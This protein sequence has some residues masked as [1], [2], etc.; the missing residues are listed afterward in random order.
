MTGEKTKLPRCCVTASMLR[1]G[2]V[3][4]TLFL[5]RPGG[6]EGGLANGGGGG[7]GAIRASRPF[8]EMRVAMPTGLEEGGEVLRRGTSLRAAPRRRGGE[9]D[10]EREE[11]KEE[12][13]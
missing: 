11:E 4:E 10:G 6:G 13:E 1:C 8:A 12:E 3:I 7:G 5:S 2:G 9:R